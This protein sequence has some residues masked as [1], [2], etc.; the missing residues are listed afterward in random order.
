[1]ERLSILEES[2]FH[3]AIG[4][5]VLARAIELVASERADEV[6]AANGFH[7]ELWLTRLLKPGP[8]P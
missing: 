7:E 2:G 3:E 1:V 6:L 4:A 8:E 5:V